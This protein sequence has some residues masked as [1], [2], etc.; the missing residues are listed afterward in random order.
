MPKIPI[1]IT[2]GKAQLN[3]FV[4]LSRADVRSDKAVAVTVSGRSWRRKGRRQPTHVATLTENQWRF[5]ALAEE[6]DV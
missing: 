4:Q 5:E 2:H 1:N 3:R 6:D